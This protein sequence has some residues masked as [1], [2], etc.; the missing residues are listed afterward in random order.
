MSDFSIEMTAE[1]IIDARTRKYFDEVLQ[2]YNTG[3][4]RSAVVMLWSV[5]VCDLLFKLDQLAT[6]YGDSIAKTI[7][8]DIEKL[9][10]QNP[11]SPDWEWALVEEIAKKTQLLELADHVNLKTLQEHRHLSAH[12]VLTSVEVLFTPSRELIRSHIRSTLEGVLT[13]P[14]MFSKKVFDALT[15]DLEAN[16]AVLPDQQSLRRYLEAKYFPHFVPHIENAVFR[17]LWRLTFKSTDA[18]CEKA[19][20]IL[21]RAIC[22]LYERRPAEIRNLIESERAYFSEL[23]LSGAPLS[24]VWEF[25]GKYPQVFNALSDAA[26]TPLVVYA[27]SSLSNFGTAWFMSPTVEQHLETILNRVTTQQQFMSGEVFTRICQTAGDA[28]CLA[29]ALDIGI[30]HYIGSISFASADT[31]FQIMVKP[32]LSNFNA[33]QLIRLLGGIEA[34]GQTH[35]RWRAKR[36]HKKV[37]EAVDAVLGA[38]FDAIQ[39]PN[40]MQSFAEEPPQQVPPLPVAPNDEDEVPF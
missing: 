11:K 21:Y 38:E 1:K 26:K 28:G 27:N 4:F 2:C 32:H 35:G 18:R 22:I 25:L 5:V 19:R 34:N 39:F 24:L 20:N 3:C 33:Q 14:A 16:E 13:K 36:D 6:A 31:N 8:K 37:K 12:P 7:L 40:F 23:H 29:K 9:R 30:A 10:A 15:E 17:S